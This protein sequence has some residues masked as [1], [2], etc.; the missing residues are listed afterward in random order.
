MLQLMEFKNIPT[1]HLKK[2]NYLPLIKRG[3]PLYNVCSRCHYINQDDYKFCSNCGFPVKGDDTHTLYMLRT[4]Q[5]KE[6]LNQSE[7][8]IAA[9]RNT[10]YVLAAFCTVG[11][12]FLF[13]NLDNRYLLT[14]LFLTMSALFF[15]LARWSLY[16]PFT[17]LLAA[18]VIVLTSATVSIF[19]EFTNTFT[20]VQG[21][22][23]III[24]MI[25]IYFLIK[26]VQG[27]YKAD[28]IK[29]EMEIS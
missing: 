26:G 3:E 2:I 27:A 1:F 5:R 15:L 11:V 20:T 25:L 18:F 19:G 28:L 8:A 4:R 29:E 21:M 7:K 22:Y 6:I 12:G 14:V 13:G 24:S 10:L 23:S 17:A 16:K 9:A